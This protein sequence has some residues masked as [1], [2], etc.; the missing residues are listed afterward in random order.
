MKNIY[1]FCLQQVAL[2]FKDMPNSINF[3]KRNFLHVISACIIVPRFI[4]QPFIVAHVF[5]YFNFFSFKRLNMLSS[6]K[7]WSSFWLTIALSPLCYW[8]TCPMNPFLLLHI[9]WLVV[10][11]YFPGSILKKQKVFYIKAFFKKSDKTI[12]FKDT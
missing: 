5:F 3:S 1:I 11:V 6:F 9:F 12:S 7:P 10:Q 4:A 8:L 2:F